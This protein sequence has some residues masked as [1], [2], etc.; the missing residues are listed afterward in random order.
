MSYYIFLRRG[1]ILLML[2]FA[3]SASAYIPPYWMIMSRMA[4]SHGRG[5]YLIDQDVVFKHG[6][7]P[8]F[9]NEKWF[10]QGE[11][12]FRLEVTGLRQLKDSLRLTFIYQKDRK[13]FLDESGVKKSASLPKDFFEPYLHFRYSK[14]IKPQLISLGIAPSA[15]LK[16]APQKYN[17]KTP[18]APSEP[19]LRLARSNGVITYALGEPVPVGSS[20]LTPGLWIEQ[21]EFV[22]RKMR[23]PS[24]A[25]LIANSYSTFNNDLKYP[26]E[27]IFRW[28]DQ[29][30][31]VRL[32][33]AKSFNLGGQNKKLLDPSSLNYKEKPELTSLWP[34]DPVIRDFYNRLR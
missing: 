19:F 21:D 15:S 20:T 23:L 31:E 4:E 29:K 3:G 24:Q 25:E 10:V 11:G 34:E 2:L 16:S 22:L 32:N 26:R 33:S 17:P 7:E 13:F 1:M 9:V 5:P 30:A 27:L 8:L 28:S 18:L 6:P 12:Q 14:H